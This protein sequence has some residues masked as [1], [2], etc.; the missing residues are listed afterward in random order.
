MWPTTFE[1][2]L[3]SWH[4]LRQRVANDSALNCLAAVN[5]WWYQSPWQSYYLHWQ[6]Q[7]TWPDPWQLLADNVYCDLARALGIMYTMVLLDR[8]DIQDAQIAEI[9]QGN[10]VL[11]HNKKYILNWERYVVV[12]TNL[13]S[14]TF[15][16]Q[17]SQVELKQQL[18]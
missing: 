12:N 18:H 13:E 8:P 1:Q 7:A 5:E 4:T 3:H 9:D 6:D 2:R 16:N 10:L 15:R 11:V 14:K 17:L